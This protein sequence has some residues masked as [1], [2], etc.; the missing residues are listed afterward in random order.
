VGVGRG[1]YRPL[2]V[3]WRGEL[4]PGPARAVAL[5]LE[6]DQV[7]PSALSLVVGV[8]GGSEVSSPN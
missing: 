7:L 3:T 1:R 4:V 6:L 2:G 8:S 5:A